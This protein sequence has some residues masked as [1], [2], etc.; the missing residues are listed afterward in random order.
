MTECVKHLQSQSEFNEC[1]FTCL[2]IYFRITQICIYLPAFKNFV[3][4]NIM[5]NILS[6]AIN[7]LVLVNINLKRL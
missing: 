3:I 4:M 2:N 7:E 5:R 6:K 1:L